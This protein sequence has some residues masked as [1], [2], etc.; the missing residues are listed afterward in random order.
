MTPHPTTIHYAEVRGVA[1]ETALRAFLDALPI[2]PGFLGAA[3]LVS[4]DQPDL[5]LVASRWAGEVPPLPLP[6]DARAWTFKVR[7]AR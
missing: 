5:A 7:E 4:P 1:A 3:L 2:L 6:T